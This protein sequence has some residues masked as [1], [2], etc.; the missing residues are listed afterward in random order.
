[1]QGG[2]LALIL[3]LALATCLLASLYPAWA[4]GRQDPVEA[5]RYE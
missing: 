2:D 4:A 5:I 3:V 1:V